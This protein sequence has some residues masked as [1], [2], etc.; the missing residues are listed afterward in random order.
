[1]FIFKYGVYDIYLDI[2]VYI[3]I[4]PSSGNQPGHGQDFQFFLMKSSNLQD[5]H[6]LKTRAHLM[7]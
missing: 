7:L 2:H 4:V 5:V 3:Y 6:D 1:M